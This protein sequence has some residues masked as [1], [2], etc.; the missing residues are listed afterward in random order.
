MPITSTPMLT[1]PAAPHTGWSHD[2]SKTACC[3]AVGYPLRPASPIPVSGTIPSGCPTKRVRVPVTVELGGG[4]GT[5]AVHSTSEES[6]SGQAGASA[7]CKEMLVPGWMSKNDTLLDSTAERGVLVAEDRPKTSRTASTVAI[8]TER[9]PA[10][11]ASTRRRPPHKS[12]HACSLPRPDPVATTVAATPPAACKST[13][14][15]RLCGSEA[16]AVEDSRVKPHVGDVGHSAMADPLARL[17]PTSTRTCRPTP[18]SNSIV[19]LAS[20]PV[21]SPRRS[22]AVIGTTCTVAAGRD[23]S[24]PASDTRSPVGAHSHQATRRI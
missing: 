10:P 2:T 15:D 7:T 20:N 5:S 17:N 13:S 14:P 24:A 19:P 11:V 3:D 23:N 1:A 6:A 18:G 4:C 12:H 9:M 22:N 8:R 21:A 16:M